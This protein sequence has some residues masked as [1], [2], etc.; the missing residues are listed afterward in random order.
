MDRRLFSIYEK[1]IIC[2]SGFDVIFTKIK[3]TEFYQ[4]LAGPSSRFISYFA[5]FPKRCRLHPPH[6]TYNRELYSITI[7]PYWKSEIF[8]YNRTLIT[9]LAMTINKPYS[10][11]GFAPNV[12]QTP[13]FRCK[14]SGMAYVS[15]EWVGKGVKIILMYPVDIGK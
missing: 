7:Y 3:T 14:K 6:K 4:K 5:L 8:H 11:T 9:L 1:D 13:Y 12:R 2:S 10:R 15:S